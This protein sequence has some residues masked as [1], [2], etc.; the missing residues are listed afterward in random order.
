MLVIR[1]LSLAF[2][3][4]IVFDEINLTISYEQKIGLVG[5]NGAGKSTFL[6]AIAQEQYIDSGSISADKKKKIGYLAQNIV[7]QADCTIF[8]QAFSAFGSAIHIDEQILALEQQLAAHNSAAE[9]AQLVEHYQ[10]LLEQKMAFDKNAALQKTTSIL[11]GLGFKQEQFDKKVAALSI[12]WRMRLALAYLLLTDADFYLFDEPTNHLDLATKDWF[13]SFLRSAPFGYLLVSH[14]QYFLDHACDKIIELERGKATMYTGNFTRYVQQKNA[15]Q[16]RLQKAYLQQQK[17]IAQK[18]EFISRFRAKA[19]K[20]GVVQSAIKQLNKIELIEVEPPLPAVHFSFPPVVRAGNIVLDVNHVSYAFGDKKILNDVSFSLMR[21][22][23]GVIIAPNGTGKTTLFNVITGNLKTQKGSLNF[24][25]NVTSAY[26]Q[27]EQSLV[28]DARLTVLET[29]L[30][31]CPTIPE[32]KIRSFLGSFLFSG[33]DVHKKIGFLSGGEKN[34]VAMVI[35]LLQNTNLLL[36]D[37]PTNHLDLYAKQVLLQA[38]QQYQGSLLL[39]SHDRLFIEQL[40]DVVFEL[41]PQ[42]VHT[43]K[44]DY[45][46]YLYHKEHSAQ[47]PINHSVSTDAQKPILTAA[48]LNMHDI[49]KN[50]RALEREIAKLENKRDKLALSINEHPYGSAQFTNIQAELKK[51]SE[52]LTQLEK[53]WEALVAQL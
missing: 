24:G 9:S 53:E 22:Q 2:G 36:L 26:F 50:A 3:D 28:L 30:E 23:K 5:R 16:E 31:K 13:L 25:H 27:Q 48:P 10:K 19:N 14:D 41:T 4:Q 45:A 49:H 51:I 18:Q 34:R 33:D 7:M 39:V 12:G 6:K 37:E 52:Q 21:G 20:A 32:A 8:E 1:D 38:L 29:V 46:S 17:E 44:G 43:Y 11:N 42:G 47:K 15:D 40:A 35:V